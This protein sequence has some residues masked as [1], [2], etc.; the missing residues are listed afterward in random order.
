MFGKA[1]V[2]ADHLRRLS[3]GSSPNRQGPRARPAR[4]LCP[5]PAP[6]ANRKV[7]CP[8]AGRVAIAVGRDK[9]VRLVIGH[10]R[11]ST[12]PSR[13]IVLF[14]QPP[15]PVF[16]SVRHY[17]QGLVPPRQN[18]SSRYALAASRVHTPVTR[19]PRQAILGH[20]E[21]PF[22]LGRRSCW[23][24]PPEARRIRTLAAT[25]LA[26]SVW[27]PVKRKKDDVQG[28]SILE[29]LEIHTASSGHRLAVRIERYDVQFMQL[30][31]WGLFRDGG[32]SRCSEP[33]TLRY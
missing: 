26:W 20:Q 28:L 1:G 17:R 15:T 12:W 21:L 14:A 33:S 2:G 6:P 19:M 30:G 24:P 22:R 11:C 27:S 16:R 3:A 8:N 10:L 25:C 29:K 9:P 23:P 31:V 4:S 5:R 32:R 18:S 7:P 13:Q